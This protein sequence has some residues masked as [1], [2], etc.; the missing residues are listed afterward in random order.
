TTFVLNNLASISSLLLTHYID[1]G[2]VVYLNGQEAYRYNMPGGAVGFSTPAT[3]NLSGS[4]G[5]LGPFALP[6]TN[7][8]N[9][10]NVIAIE[11]HQQ[12]SGS[13]DIFMGAKL[14]ATTNSAA[15]A[16]LVLNEIL[17][18]NSNIEEPDGST[19]DWV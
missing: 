11:A 15:S 6:L 18:N 8:F 17:A 1:D 3:L 9:G 16:G 2:C 5:E 4:P 19:P 14:D 10:A 13:A 12:S 7:V